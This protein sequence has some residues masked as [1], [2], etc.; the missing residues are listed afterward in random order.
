MNNV[1]GEWCINGYRH[2]LVTDTYLGIVGHRMVRCIGYNSPRNPTNATEQCSIRKRT[3][4][5]FETS[6]AIALSS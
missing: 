2:V 5:Y 4:S 6:G 1:V 3:G